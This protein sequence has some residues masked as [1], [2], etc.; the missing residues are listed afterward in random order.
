MP[1]EK[2]RPSFTFTEDRLKELQAV[3]PEAFADG[4]I[5]WDVLHEALD[6]HLED[7]SQ[8]H[9]GLFWPGKREARRLPLG[10]AWRR[11]CNRHCFAG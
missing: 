9:F 7:E 8:E 10:R 2:L 4:K 11:G 1:I 6:E 3:V 5:N